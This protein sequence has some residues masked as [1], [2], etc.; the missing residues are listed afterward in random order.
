MV[1]RPRNLEQADPYFDSVVLLAPFSGEDTDTTAS[2]LSNSGH[3]L[4]FAG[5]AALDGDI[6]KFGF[7]SAQ[8]DGT[9]DGITAADSTDFDLGS[10]QF[11]VEAHVRFNGDPGIQQWL[12]LVTIL[13]LATN[14]LG[15]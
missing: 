3:T 14:V 12:L 2:D 5:N 4:T 13:R 7:T 9:G 10:G 6:R 1:T 15:L 8:F 11:T